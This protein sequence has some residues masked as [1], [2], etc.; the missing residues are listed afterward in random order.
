MHAALKKS[1][2]CAVLVSEE[3]QEPI[4]VPKGLRGPYCVAFDPL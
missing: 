3:E 2:C 4:L 1:G